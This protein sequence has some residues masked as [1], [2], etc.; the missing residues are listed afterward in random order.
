MPQTRQLLMFLILILLATAAFGQGTTASLVGT[1]T[2]SGQPLPGVTVTISSPALQGVRTAI[3]GEGGGYTFPSLPPGPYTVTFELTGMQTL[4]RKMTLGLAQSARAD[5]E[6][7]VAAVAEAI[8]VT[9]SAPAVLESPGVTTNFSSEIVSKLPVGRNIRDTTL[10]APGV[11]PNGVNRQITINGGPSYDNI[12]LVNGVV[13]NE[14]LRGQPHNLFIEDAIQET[15]IITTG[16]SAE[17]GRFTGG[18]VSTLTKSGGNEFSGSFRDSFSNPRWTKVPDF[19]GATKATDK[20][21]QVYEATLGGRIIRDRLWFFA[22]GRQAKTAVARTTFQ[23]GI[24]FNNSFDEKRYEG[25]LTGAITSRHSV[26]VS[27]LDVKNT[28]TNNVFPQIYDEASIVPSRDL[29]NRL[30]T[31]NYNG[32]LTNNLVAEGQWSHKKFAFVNSGG[33]FTDR[34][35]GTWISDQV[36]GARMNAPV[37]CGVCKPEERNSG[38][39]GGKGTYFLSTRRMGNH[40]FAIG[41]DRFQEERISDNHQAGSDYVISARVIVVGKQVFPLFDSRTQISWQ[42]ILVESP[43]TDLQSDALFINDKWDFNNH[44]SFNIGVR[45]DTNNAVDADGQTISD[46]SNVSPRLGLIYDIRGDGR[47]RITANFARYVTKIGDGSNVFSTAQAA[48]NPGSF[49]YAYAGPVVNGPGT[50]NYVSP[51]EALAILFGWFDSIGGTSNTDYIAVSYPGYASVFRSSLKSPSADEITLGYGIQLGPRAYVR[52]DGDRREWSN[53]YARQVNEPALRLT[54]PNNIPGDM[55]VTVNDDKFTERRYNG[56]TLQGGWNPSRFTLGGNY[57]WSTLKGND[58]SEGG[59][60]ATIR[61]TPGEI[62]YPEYLNYPNRRPMGYLGQDRRHRARLWTAYDLPTPIGTFSLSAIESYDSGFAYSAVGT[63]DASGRNANFRY[64]GIPTNPGYV[65]NGLGTTHDYYFSKRGEFRT[66][67]R[68]ATDVAIVYS[69]PL[70]GKLRFFARGDVLNV[71]NTNKIV[72]PALLN[73]DVIT[74]RTGGAASGLK[75]FNPFTDTPIECPQGATASTCSGLGAHWQ[76]GT[77]FGQS[78]SADALM[79]SDRTLAPRTY[80][81]GLGLRF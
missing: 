44:L 37:F 64:T 73:S 5:A 19:P 26:I 60:T 71:F 80:R 27:Y 43:G 57:T 74:A 65:L 9:A 34:I 15:T 62:F 79:V 12:F 38:G 28:E 7:K 54:P 36:T 2:T 35:K 4:T 14:N 31:V 61:N 78:D 32:I 8:T 52:I 50:T 81:F 11:N 1:V 23:T 46:D 51:H 22:A 75:P 21:N 29:P 53:F 18:V 6:L 16:I 30:E 77:R 39:F 63:I 56:I 17:Y 68:M 72:D 41:A 49:T 33:R 76:K 40:S 42:P 67:D 20:T 69:L 3:T 66:D 13:V 55:S 10:L 59:G 45:Y 24:P 25:K 70:F 58:V 48:G 47:H